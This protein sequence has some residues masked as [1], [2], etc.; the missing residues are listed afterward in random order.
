MHKDTLTP[1]ENADRGLDRN[2]PAGHARQTAY[3][4]RAAFGKAVHAGAFKTVLVVMGAGDAGEVDIACA[5][6]LAGAGHRVVAL[7]GNDSIPAAL[8]ESV[9]AGQ[10]LALPG[11][12]VGTAAMQ[13][14]IKDLAAPFRA[15]DAVVGIMPMPLRRLALLDAQAPLAELFPLADAA[16]L[17][18]ATRAAMPG[19]IAGGRGRVIVVTPTGQHHGNGAGHG[20]A[21]PLWLTLRAELDA[22]GIRFTR[23]AAGPMARR[24]VMNSEPGN[25]PRPGGMSRD[26]L[27]PADVAEAVAWTLAQP[28]RVSVRDIDIGA[29]PC[30]Q[31]V[32]SLRE[33]E[34][35]EWTACGKTSEEISCILE[36]SVS[37]VNFHVKNL[38]CKLQCCNKTAAVAR[39]ALLGLL[40]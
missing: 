25:R 8:Q 28:R 3:P 6:T 12:A 7:M 11:I 10:V 17:V 26:L 31:P 16:R 14:A 21:D 30:C 22:L 32:L 33:Q 5:A 24:P 34:V 15:V 36:L 2:A 23:L 1:L 9:A 35:L 20:Q 37:A 18:A 39:A 29:A 19:L 38:L 27:S 4:P 40:A 13:K